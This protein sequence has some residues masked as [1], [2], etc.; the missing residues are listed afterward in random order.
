MCASVS[1]CFRLFIC[2]PISMLGFGSFVCLVA[3]TTS[4]QSLNDSFVVR[5]CVCLSVCLFLVWFELV[6]WLVLWPVCLCLS[7]CVYVWLC[8]CD[9]C[10]AVL[11]GVVICFLVSLFD[12]VY[13]LDYVCFFLAVL[14]LCDF[15]L[16]SCPCFLERACLTSC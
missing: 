15:V 4:V 7:L 2:L 14:V 5:F 1:S 8:C 6:G 12:H 3:E 10:C 11:L 16:A 13:L 9:L